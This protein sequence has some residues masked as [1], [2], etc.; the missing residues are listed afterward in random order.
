MIRAALASALVLVAAVQPAAAVLPEPAIPVAAARG[1][2]IDLLRCASDHG[3]VLT[4]GHRAGPAPN[5]PENALETAAYTLAQG[6]MLIEMDVRTTRDGVLVLMHDATLDRTTTGQG[7]VSDHSWAELQALRLVD[8]DGR[9]TD[10]RIPRLIDAIEWMRHRGILAI[11]LKEDA[12]IGPIARM[13]GEADA[14]AFTLVST[15][16]PAQAMMV[17]Q[18]DPQITITHP[19]STA[20]DLEVLRRVGVNM[21]ALTAWAGLEQNDPRAPAL[22]AELQ[23]QGVPVLYAT[24]FLADREM[25]ESGDYS[26]FETL[27]ADGVDIIPTDLHMQAY[28][29]VTAPRAPAQ[30]LA[31]CGGGGG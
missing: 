7:A 30:V 26:L 24:L 4:S 14:H 25:R 6:P 15:Y 16:R 1:R 2:T 22:W 13:I 5:Y 18:A 28:R 10:F 31:Q 29:T 8:N 9:E 21:D 19:V 23:R 12:S 20:E 27:A 3:L 17:H 11:D